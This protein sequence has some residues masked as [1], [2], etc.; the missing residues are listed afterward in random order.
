M[1]ILCSM[2]KNKLKISLII[3]CALMAFNLMSMSSLEDVSKPYVGVYECKYIMFGDENLLD[4]FN[5]V[6]F[7]LLLNGVYKIEFKDKHNVK[8]VYRGHYEYDT[9]NNLITIDENVFG[10][11]IKK[12]FIAEKGAID[13][14]VQYGD[15]L[16]AIKFEM[17]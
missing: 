14:T 6:K 15:K 9:A 5:Y 16:L 1:H 8:G 7:E 2:K 3:P 12:S 11:R 17:H 13:V 10:N 4:K